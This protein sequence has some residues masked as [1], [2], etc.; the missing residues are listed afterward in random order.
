MSCE[1]M[2]TLH[3]A[4]N[5]LWNGGAISGQ[6]DLFRLPV[7]ITKSRAESAATAMAF[8]TGTR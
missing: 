1:F 5:I 2:S 3:R 6:V 4:Y 7:Y 8:A